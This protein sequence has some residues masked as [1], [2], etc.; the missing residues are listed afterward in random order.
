MPRPKQLSVSLMNYSDRE[1]PRPKPLSVS[2]SHSRMERKGDREK[3]RPKQLSVSHREK[4][5]PKPLSVS[6][7]H[8]RMERKGD[9]EKPRPEQLSVDLMNY[10]DREKLRQRKGKVDNGLYSQCAYTW[11]CIINVCYFRIQEA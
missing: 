11:I 4:P 6:Q 1:K 2:Q 9:R 7:S 10:S 3:P 5:R 8:S